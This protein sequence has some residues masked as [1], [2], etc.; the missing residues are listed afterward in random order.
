MISQWFSVPINFCGRREWRFRT[1]GPWPASPQKL[2]ALPRASFPK[3]QFQ[4]PKSGRVESNRN[5]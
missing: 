3:G 4:N 5:T 2:L 1:F